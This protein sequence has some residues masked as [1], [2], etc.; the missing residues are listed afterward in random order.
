MP[1]CSSAESTNR[2]RPLRWTGWLLC[3]VVTLGATLACS[4]DQPPAICPSAEEQVRFGFYD[5]YPPVSSLDHSAGT[6]GHV[7][8][9]ADLLNAIEQMRDTNLRFERSPVSEWTG[10]WLQPA[11]GTFDMVGGGISILETR[12]RQADG[13]VVVAFS[14]GHIDFRS[15]LLIRQADASR[16]ETPADLSAGDRV[17]VYR[18]TTS[19]SWL[20]RELGIVEADGVLRAGTRV[21]LPAG[22]VEADGS[23]R[24]IVA[25]GSS[26]PALT[27]RR[28]IMPAHDGPDL[29]YL[30]E[31]PG[32]NAQ[33]LENDDLDAIADDAIAAQSWVQ[34][35][36]GSLAVTA[37]GAD[38]TRGGFAIAVG[39]HRLICLNDR[40]RWLT[41]NGQIEFAEWLADS[42]V[43]S[44]RAALWN[45]D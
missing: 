40:I 7:G 3:L 43:F 37:L 8:Y 25:P 34:Q 42:Q 16:I 36:G 13:R 23:D 28:A 5:A 19:E 1:A 29:I 33:M 27:G 17:G 14:D 20:L 18:D 31:V 9:E 15:V 35:S 2:L 22:V 10:I 30:D 11:S 44:S 45:R 12:T 41:D 21:A 39:D 4:N 38:R 24:F 32:T 26:S 6:G